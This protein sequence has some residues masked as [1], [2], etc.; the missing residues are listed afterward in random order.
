[1]GTIHQQ[2][3]QHMKLVL[4]ESKFQK[5]IPTRILFIKKEYCFMKIKQ[6]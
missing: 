3:V 5:T 1:M 4:Q 2:V 6:D